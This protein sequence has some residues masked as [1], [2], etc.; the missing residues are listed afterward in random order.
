MF[1]TSALD[2]TTTT[3]SFDIKFFLYHNIRVQYFNAVR[4][5]SV[6]LPSC[7]YISKNN[8]LIIYYAFV[9]GFRRAR[10]V[11]INRCV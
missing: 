6:P 5:R 2:I 3:I 1:E 9:V 8:N 10:I 7:T 11:P 4:T